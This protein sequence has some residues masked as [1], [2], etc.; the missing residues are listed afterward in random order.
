M[1]L[2]I[3]KIGFFPNHP[4]KALENR[5]FRILLVE[6]PIEIVDN[7]MHDGVWKNPKTLKII[8][9]TDPKRIVQSHKN[10]FWDKLWREEGVP[11]GK[12]RTAS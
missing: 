6:K 3:E 4:K 8:P 5:G 12:R 11:N 10:A 7:F 1:I 9:L 2:C